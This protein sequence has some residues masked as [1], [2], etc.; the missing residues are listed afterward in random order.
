VTNPLHRLSLSP[1]EV[2]YALADLNSFTGGAFN[3]ALSAL[4][5]DIAVLYDRAPD[6]YTRRPDDLAAL[7]TEEPWPKPPSP[8]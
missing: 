8:A 3:H 2:L 5:F 4:H 1:K 6:L 7:L